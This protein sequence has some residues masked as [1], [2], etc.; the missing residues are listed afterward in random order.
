MAEDVR[1]GGAYVEIRAK[2][3]QLKKDFNRI[4]K[5][6]EKVAK[7]IESSFRK[8]KMDM[9]NRLLTMKLSQVQQLHKALTQQLQNK[10]KA[11]ADISSIEK[12]RI[13][14]R[15]VENALQGVKDTSAKTEGGFKSLFSGGIGAATLFIGKITAA[16]FAIKKI[17]DTAVE[18]AKL[19]NLQKAFEKISQN[20]GIDSVKL[21]NDLKSATA[22]AVKEFDLLKAV[23]KGS[24]LGVDIK[25]MP[26]LLRFAAIRA[27]ET[28]ESID[29]LVDSIITGLGR[30]SPLILD[31]L[32]LTM[33]DLDKSVIDVAASH[34]V[35][36]KEVDELARAEY[37]T[38]AAVRVAQKAIDGSAISLSNLATQSAQLQTGWD[39]FAKNASD[40]FTPV[41]SV[42]LNIFNDLTDAAGALDKEIED[43][44]TGK[45]YSKPMP[46]LKDEKPDLSFLSSKKRYLPG[47]GFVTIIEK[48][49]PIETVA[50]IEKK[51]EDLQ[52]A[53]KGLNATSSDYAKNLKEIKRLQNLLDPLGAAEERSKIEKSL[54][55]ELTFL[56]SNYESYRKKLI[57]EQVKKFREQGLAEIEIQKYVNSELAKLADERKKFFNPEDVNWDS[58][59]LEMLKGANE[60]DKILDESIDENALDE[61]NK[62]IQES[63]K[64]LEDLRLRAITN[65]FDQREAAINQEYD[66]MLIRFQGNQEIMT[67]IE[68]ARQADLAR[69]EQDRYDKSISNISAI[70]NALE[71]AFSKSG[72][73]FLSYLNQALQI[74][75]NIAA[76][77]RASKAAES[78]AEGILGIAA[79]VIP[80]IGFLSSLFKARGGPVTANR[81]VIVGDAPGGRLTPYSELFIPKTAGTIFPNNALSGLGASEQK[82]NEL[83]SA[84]KGQTLTM[85]NLLREFANN[86]NTPAIY[87]DG[88]KISKQIMKKSGAI[89]KSG[90]VIDDKTV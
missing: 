5:D 76:A 38:E 48:E 16:Y 25:A 87:I 64:T 15:S 32:G 84:T 44:L 8:H 2:A 36:I 13:A 10:I 63:I 89:E 11:N 1:L 26:T 24:F 58:V 66:D 40:T 21:L 49:K 14:L 74:T 54:Y 79:S 37:L 12:T 80:G 56:S 31:N 61:Q 75:L 53:Q 28:G 7:D 18:N 65:E 4:P 29:Y 3:D 81:P 41:F 52:K 27:Q 70:G 45:T 22:G 6:A 9:D 39:K 71:N 30:K 46:E 42:I 72:D 77:I 90:L 57:D 47:G 59:L 69:L 43:L 35:L 60:P 51:I 20:A 23:N 68:K 88:M 67:E 78:G 83:I 17:F 34:G 50:A 73:S 55:D 85:V 33:K 19:Q 82:I 62:K 86:S